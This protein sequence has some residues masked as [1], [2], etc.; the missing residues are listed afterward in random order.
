M[1]KAHNHMSPSLIRPLLR[2][3]PTVKHISPFNTQI[4]RESRHKSPITLNTQI[5]REKRAI[6]P[7]VKDDCGHQEQIGGVESWLR[8]LSS[9]KNADPNFPVSEREM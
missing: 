6:L 1:G 7:G 9:K 5:P 2:S 4:P 8:A 3:K